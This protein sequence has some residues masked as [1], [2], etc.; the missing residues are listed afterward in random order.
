MSKFI[1][2]GKQSN[3]SIN[4][5]AFIVSR[6]L[7]LTIVVVFSLAIPVGAEPETVLTGCLNTRS[8]EFHNIA[9]GLEPFMPCSPTETQVTWSSGVPGV[10]SRL[11]ALEE[12][13][14]EM[15]SDLAPLDLTVNWPEE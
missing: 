6:L 7:L 1:D 5:L 10:E 14:A 11:A 8:G 13:I 12:R 9:L 15:E 4:R 3:I 2:S